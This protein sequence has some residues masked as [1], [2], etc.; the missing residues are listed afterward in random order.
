[1]EL[2]LL[3]VGLKT[4]LSTIDFVVPAA[5]PVITAKV[6]LVANSPIF[7]LYNIIATL[8]ITRVEHK[9]KEK[10]SKFV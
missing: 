2:P 3:L 8:P 7:L 6:A 5:T 4:L 10:K 9:N 1:L